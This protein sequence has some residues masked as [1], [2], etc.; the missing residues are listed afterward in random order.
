MFKGKISVIGSGFVGSTCAY[1]LMLSSLVSEIVIVD[2]N[3]EKAEGDALDMSHG[4]SF[5]T[6]VK[7]VAGSYADTK[8]SDLYIIT[9]GA[10][11][12][13]GETR[14]DLLKRNTEILKDI[15]TN[16]ERYCGNDALLLV[17]SNPVDILTYI[18]YKLSGFDK[19]KVIGSGTVLDTSRLKYLI[20]NQIN[21]DPR[22]I[23]TY[24]IGEHGDT[25][26]AAWSVTSVAG[27]NIQEYCTVS[28]KCTIENLNKDSLLEQ[29]RK[30]AYEIIEKKGATYYAVALAVT[31]IVEAII[32][33][34]NS[35]LTV[36]GLFE[37][38]YGISDICLSAPALV[39]KN[40]ID[41]I[42]QIPFCEE[43]IKGLRNSANT[44]KEIARGVGV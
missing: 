43:E 3:K 39:N 21:V 19:S 12:Q 8:N 2:V 14:I 6:P 20:S 1:T 11:Q 24:I 31:R 18:T 4:G 25:E 36:S 9:A 40:G 13:E 41:K 30:A 26:V 32:G 38:E 37:G 44:L 22:N 5:V 15:V 34:E 33:D 23:H 7:V 29:T 42:L 10:N 16:I 17:V 35:I 28:G 27:L